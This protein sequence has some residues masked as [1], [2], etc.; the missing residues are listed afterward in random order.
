[1]CPATNSGVVGVHLK[2]ADCSKYITIIKMCEI[3][4]ANWIC[5]DYKRT[6]WIDDDVCNGDWISASDAAAARLTECFALWRQQRNRLSCRHI[7]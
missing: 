3:E 4:T 1:M 7:K 5:F 2:R 6:T